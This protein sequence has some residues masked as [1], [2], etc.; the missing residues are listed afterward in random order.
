MGDVFRK[1]ERKGSSSVKWDY[2]VQ[3]DQV[4]FTIADSDYASPKCILNALTKRVKAGHFG[5]SKNGDDYLEA[6]KN[7]YHK[8]HA[9]EIQSKWVLPTSNVLTACKIALESIGYRGD[10]V[11]IMPPVYSSFYNLLE[12]LERKIVCCDLINDNEKYRIDFVKLEELFKRGNHILLLCSPHNPVGRVWRR[13][14]LEKLSELC[15]KYSVTIISDEIHSDFILGSNKFISMLE[16][17]EV[18]RQLYVLSAPTK[19]FSLAGL[20]SA[21]LIVPD[22]NNR[23]SCQKTLT[24]NCCSVVNILAATATKEAYT[25]PEAFEWVQKQ[26]EHILKNYQTVKEYLAKYLPEAKL[27][28]QEGTYV[29]WLNLKCL[30][31]SSAEIVDLLAKGGVLVNS[32]KSYGADYDGYIR[33]CVACSQKQLKEG[34]KRFVRVLGAGKKR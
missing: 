6:I 2:H 33:W 1:V 19:T 17:N 13:D 29:L 8:K 21:Y 3:G 28:E 34:L 30:D 23:N 14:E 7:W 9:C 22:E 16:F 26:N 31:K 15:A 25:N 4:L 11:I 20:L 10:R 27:P 24:R 32:G 12:N 5:Y 18:H